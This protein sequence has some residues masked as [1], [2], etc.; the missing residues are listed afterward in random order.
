[1]KNEFLFYFPELFEKWK[2]KRLQRTWR[3]KFRKIFDKDDLRIALTQPRYHFGEWFVAIHYA[4]KG[5]KVLVEKYLY[6]NH[7]RK[8]K[9]ISRFFTPQQIGILKY[10]NPRHQS[11]DLFVYRDKKFFF[12]EVKLGKDRLRRSQKNCFKNIE[13]K[14]RCE[15]KVFYL[16]PSAEAAENYRG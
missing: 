15:V 9:I 14:L 13:K 1:M 3:R 2:A 11:P 8:F 4:N 5:Y 7:S 6:R 10:P 16:K 12:V